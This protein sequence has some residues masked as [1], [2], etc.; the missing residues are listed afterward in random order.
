MHESILWRRPVQGG[1]ETLVRDSVEGFSFAVLDKGIYFIHPSEAG[2][3]CTLP[4]L[5]FRTGAVKIIASI[6][7]PG[8]GGL[9]VSPDG[10]YALYTQ[11]DQVSG[12]DLML[13]ETSGKEV[14]RIL[15]HILRTLVTLLRASCCKEL[16]RFIATTASMRAL[17]GPFGP[18]R[19]ALGRKQHAVGHYPALRSRPVERCSVRG[20]LRRP[21]QVHPR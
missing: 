9:A 19:R 18:S 21:G 6:P 17:F 12:S 8:N 7:H 15:R 3:N 13:V 5:S 20:G 2:G 11:E 14:G 16:R 10:R 1:E 4:F